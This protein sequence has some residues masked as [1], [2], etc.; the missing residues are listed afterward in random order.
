MN[1]QRGQQ[2]RL[3]MQGERVAESVASCMERVAES[4]VSCMERVAESV[5][6][7]MEATG[8]MSFKQGI[9]LS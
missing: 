4:V 6:S 8:R 3:E 1:I 7:C 5:A 9:L 2:E